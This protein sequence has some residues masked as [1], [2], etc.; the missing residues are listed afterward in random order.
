MDPSCFA[1]ED[2]LW[3]DAETFEEAALAARRSHESAAY[4]MAI[5]LYAGELLPEDRY[6][7]WAEDER[8]NLRR[9]YLELLSKLAELY[10]ERGEYDPATET[11]QR[12]VAEEPTNEG[13]HTSLM[14]LYTI[15]DRREDALAQY[16]R[17]KEVLW[18]QLDTE[19]AAETRR[20]REDITAGRVQPVGPP[21]LRRRR[22]PEREPTTCP[23][24]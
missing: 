11:L 3:V 20:L 1:R 16:E 10:E 6:E 13:A 8:V 2:E 14:R 21:F 18:K 7:E 22:R 5:D 12:V 24:R 9:T 19:P 15:S 23:S 17:L 4:R